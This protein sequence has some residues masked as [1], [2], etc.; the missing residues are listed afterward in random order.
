MDANTSR[1][2][3]I[4]AAPV[5]ADADSLLRVAGLTKRYGDE[6]ALVD[7]AFDA[8]RRG[9]GPD[10]SE[11]R[12]QDDVARS[13]RRS[14]AGRLRRRRLARRTQSSPQAPP[15]GRSSTCPRYPA[16]RATS[17][18]RGC[19]AFFAGVYRRPVS[20]VAAVIAA[21][22]LGPVLPSACTHY[23]RVSTAACSLALGLIAPHPL[24]L[25]DEPFDGFDL[26]QTREM[27]AVL[28]RAAAG[29][30][31][32]CSPSINSPMPKAVC[33]RFVL[34]A[35][36]RMRGEGTLAELRARSGTSGRDLEEIF[37]ALT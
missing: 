17:R 8:G 21:L 34:L 19:W 37:L 25:M 36:G 3:T 26:R 12:R 20:H 27:M 24:L 23:P 9:P 31:A 30:R 5:D 10:R 28:R 32:F 33:D 1:N 4:D 29:G 2:P 13:R 22:G 18:S 7:I 16:L 14:A 11:R 15:R 35:D 6:V